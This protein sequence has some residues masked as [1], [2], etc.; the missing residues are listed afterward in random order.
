MT[1]ANES[2]REGIK[3]IRAK[4]LRDES[5]LESTHNNFYL[6][7]K[8]VSAVTLHCTLKKLNAWIWVGYHKKWWNKRQQN[9]TIKMKTMNEHRIRK[10]IAEYLFVC[11][12][13][14]VW[15]VLV[16]NRM[17][18][19]ENKEIKFKLKKVNEHW[20]LNRLLYEY[21]SEYKWDSFDHFNNIVVCGS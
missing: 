20:T 12:M 2:L 6:N 5:T 21:H 1:C 18:W 13:C 14:G 10:T 9:I 15:C 17:L 7:R 3:F 11:V 8:L 4:S 16:M 19:T